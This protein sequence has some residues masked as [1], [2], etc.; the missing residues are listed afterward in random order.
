MGCPTN[1]KKRNE[2]CK[3]ANKERNKK[4]LELRIAGASERGIAAEV[5]LSDTQVH[6]I[7]VQLIEDMNKRMDTRAAVMQRVELERLDKM[8]LAL[9]ANRNDPRTADSL[10]RIMER[11][12][13]YLGLDAPTK[14]ETVNRQEGDVKM[15]HDFSKLPTE[16]LDKLLKLIDKAT[17]E[18]D[19]E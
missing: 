13:R 11:R 1:I 18:E 3:L 5:G 17:T 9:F 8:T 19:F 14:M 12:S 2:A 10:L 7:L 4:I 6:R 15:K 16:D